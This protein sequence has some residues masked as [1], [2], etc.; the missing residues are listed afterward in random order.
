MLVTGCSTTIRESKERDPRASSTGEELQESSAT[1]ASTLS[2]S[3][4]GASRSLAHRSI[5]RRLQMRRL[6]P[7]L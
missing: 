7:G 6:G 5:S 2:G 4:T 1:R 3:C